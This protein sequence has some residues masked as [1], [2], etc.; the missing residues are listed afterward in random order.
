MTDQDQDISADMRVLRQAADR[1][2]VG[3]MLTHLTSP[4]EVVQGL[5]QFTNGRLPSSAEE[6]RTLLL[7]SYAN[8]VC[9]D[10]EKLSVSDV[11]PWYDVLKKYAK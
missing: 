9:V 7:T 1:L 6:T 10:L 3:F 5:L 8:L 4:Q 2:C 11:Q